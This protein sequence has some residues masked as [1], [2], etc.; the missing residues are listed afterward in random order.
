VHSGTGCDAL[1]KVLACLNIPTITKDVYK[2]YE[3]IV[4][5]GIEEAAADS[6]KRAAHEERNLVIE[7]MEKI[8]Q[9]L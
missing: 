2:K 5:K 4:G 1:N 6:C 3:Q 8:C 7:N 9:E